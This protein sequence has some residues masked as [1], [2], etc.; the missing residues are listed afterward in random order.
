MK[1]GDYFGAIE[2]LT[3]VLEN[4]PWSIGSHQ[5]RSECHLNVGDLQ[6]AANDIHALS[7]LIP[8]NTEAYLQLSEIHY[9]LGDADQALMNIRECLKLDQDHKKC[10]DFYK[11]LK[12]LAK[13]IE[14][15]KKSHDESRY[16]DCIRAA[17]SIIELVGQSKKFIQQGESFICACNSKAKYTQKAIETCTKVLN[18]NENDIEALYNRAQ[19]YITEENYDEA[20][21]DCNKAKNIENS[22][23]FNECVMKIQKLIKQSKKRDYYKILGVKRSASKKEIIKAYRKMA[24]EWHP[25]QH[26]EGADKE[27]AQKMFIDI[28]AA[29]EVLTDQG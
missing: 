1:R 6:R 21:N 3:K 15:M 2:L 9:E 29:K 20:L 16:D 25:D 12:K 26:P 22:D 24:Q 8:D 17:Q 11:K 28:A 5:L 13:F 27:K 4:C 10:S 18:D 19:A 14:N 23:R 7:K